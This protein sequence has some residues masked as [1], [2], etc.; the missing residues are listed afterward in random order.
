MLSKTS[1]ERLSNFTC[2]KLTQGPQVHFHVIP[3]P[4]KEQGL[5]IEWPQQKADMD[6]LKELHADLKSK[7]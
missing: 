6:A 3:K 2:L 1:A 7:M 5:G 4:D